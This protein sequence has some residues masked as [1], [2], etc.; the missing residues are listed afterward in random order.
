VIGMR[1]DT[2]RKSAEQFAAAALIRYAPAW[3]IWC[4]EQPDGSPAA[5]YAT[6]R[7][8]GAGE[9]RTVA[10][11]SARQLADA[12]AEQERGGPYPANFAFGRCGR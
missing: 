3:V 2:C 7:D 9:P 11:D 1:V 4:S 6:R 5:W 10:C 12:L 8:P